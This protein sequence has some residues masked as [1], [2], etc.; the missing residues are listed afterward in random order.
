MKIL[1]NITPE[2]MLCDLQAR[3]KKGI[4]EELATPVAQAAGVKVEDMVRVL[5]ERERL[6]STGVGN[7]IGIPHGKMKELKNL[8]LGFGIS[9]Q[10]V[11][12]ESIDRKPT[13]IFFLLAVPADSAGLHLAMLAQISRLLRDEAFRKR[14]MAID[15]PQEVIQAIGEADQEF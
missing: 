5:L 12:F 9:R 1:D 7:G 15:S 11:D 4:I 8:H 6:G 3:D 2:C 13:H 10:G 14:L